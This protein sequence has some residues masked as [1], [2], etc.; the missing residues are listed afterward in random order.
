MSLWKAFFKLCWL[1]SHN[2][3]QIVDCDERRVFQRCVKCGHEFQYD[4]Q[5]EMS[6]H[7][8]G[9]CDKAH[10]CL[11][12][13][14]WKPKDWDRCANEVCDLNPNGPLWLTPD[15]NLDYDLDSRR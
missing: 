15:G 5:A 4:F 1:L 6:P 7:W 11:L 10:T 2:S 9:F 13:G 8:V 3:E 12:C 14:G